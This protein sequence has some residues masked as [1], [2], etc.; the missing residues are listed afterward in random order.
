MV[1]LLISNFGIAPNIKMEKKRVISERT[2]P[3]PFKPQHQH[4]QRYSNAGRTVVSNC[5]YGTERNETKR[6]LA[7]FVGE[8]L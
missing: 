7:L 5:E 3:T 1:S 2:D 8:D 6:S 4:V